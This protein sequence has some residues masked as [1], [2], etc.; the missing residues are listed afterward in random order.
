[1]IRNRLVV[2]GLRIW[3]PVTEIYVKLTLCVQPHFALRVREAVV[4]RR[5]SLIYLTQ[6]VLYTYSYGHSQQP[7]M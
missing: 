1:M 2:G 7:P 3:G 6:A 5:S 4:Q